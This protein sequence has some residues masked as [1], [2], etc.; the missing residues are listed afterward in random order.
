MHDA[1]PHVLV[2]LAIERVKIPSR[3]EAVNEGA[4]L[5]AGGRMHDDARRLHEDHEVVVDVEHLEWDARVG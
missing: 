5:A 4:R 2:A 3:Q 1:R